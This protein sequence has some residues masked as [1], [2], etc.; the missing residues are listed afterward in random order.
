M[1]RFLVLGD[2]HG[3]I[4]KLREILEIVEEKGPFDAVLSVGDL[5]HCLPRRLST[6][7]YSARE[8]S[9][10]WSQ[11]EQVHSTIAHF[12]KAPFYFVPGNHDFRDGYGERGYKSNLDAQIINIAGI[13]ICGIGGSLGNFGWPYE[14]SE[15]FFRDLFWM[16]FSGGAPK[17]G[18]VLS[19]APPLGYCDKTVYG[20]LTG[21]QAL[22]AFTADWEGVLLCGHIHEA[23][24]VAARGSETVQSL[25]VNT[26]SFGIPYP[27]N[28]AVVLDFDGH[29]IEVVFHHSKKDTGGVAAVLGETKMWGTRSLDYLL[30]VGNLPLEE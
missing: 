19:H 24:G 26:G 13:P 4:K 27:S 5:S 28:C 22:S 29:N 12:T 20:N 23:A 14:V 21:S 25:V 11:V 6:K 7:T 15:E 17:N 8:K 3:Q 30:M 16:A 9:E 2:I 1:A 18:I 10:F